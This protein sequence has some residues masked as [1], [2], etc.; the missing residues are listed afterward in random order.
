M[1]EWHKAFWL[2]FKGHRSACMEAPEGE[3]AKRAATELTGAEV[4]TVERIPY[5]ADPRIRPFK[6]PKYG[7]MPS[8]CFRP[9]ECS[10]RTACP[11]NY[12]CTE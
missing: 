12:S 10:G 1:S 2:T 8:F 5:P 11:Q 9:E 3:E 4:L 7:Q 6:H